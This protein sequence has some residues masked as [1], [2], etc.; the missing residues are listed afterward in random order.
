MIAVESVHHRFVNVARCNSDRAALSFRVDGVWKFWSYSQLVARS[1]QIAQQMLREGAG[2]GIAIG[3]VVDRHPDTIAAL[4]A[5][6]EIGAFVVPVS[7]VSPH[8]RGGRILASAGVQMI[9]TPCEPAGHADAIGD[10]S[11]SISHT[12][13]ASRNRSSA[14]LSLPGKGDGSDLAY[15]MFTSG[16]TGRPKGV[17]V[18][19]RAISRL[20]LDQD[21]VRFDRTR[22]FL[23]AA[24]MNFDASLF[25]IWGALLHG[26]LCV[27]FPSNVPITSQVL[28]DVITSTSVTTAWLPASLFDAV[29]SHDVLSL[30]SLSELVIGGEALSVDHVRQARAAL[31]DVKIVNGYGPTENTTFTTCY[32]IPRH[33][34]ESLTRIPIGRAING[35][36]VVVVDDSLQEVEPG[37]EGELLAMGSGLALGY[38]GDPELSRELFVTVTRSDGQRCLCYRTGDRVVELNDG[39]LD[40]IGRRDDQVKIHGNRIEPIEI[41]TVVAG[42]VGVVQCRVRVQIDGSRKARLIA[43][44][45]LDHAASLDALKRKIVDVLPAFMVPN[46][47]HA[48]KSLPLTANGKLD[49]AQ[50]T[51]IGD[52][53]SQPVQMNLVERAWH[54]VLGQLPVTSSTNFFDAGG[55]SLEAIRL[56][57]YLEREANLSLEPTFTFEFTTT[58]QQFDELSRLQAVADGLCGEGSERSMGQK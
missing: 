30:S 34:P 44:V 11:I 12:E 26:G 16:S 38:L 19:H 45:V 8:S 32:E 58:G 50:L 35:T 41:E 22:V 6:F 13:L 20:V 48:L 43:Y 4:V 40:F 57:D 49:V 14:A 55:R 5:V 23:Q 46:E 9:V 7:E 53:E 3:I 25:E 51:A 24:P 56:H 17:A 52:N 37:T 33:L 10:D 47:V 54:K 28:R 36:E 29:V 27:L 1:R 31:P 15:V 21:Y 2:P 39:M 42:L 18:P